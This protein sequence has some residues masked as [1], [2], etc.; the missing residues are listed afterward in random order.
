MYLFASRWHVTLRQSRNAQG[1]NLFGY[2]YVSLTPREDSSAIFFK[3][4][5]ERYGPYISELRPTALDGNW[6]G[7]VLYVK[8][9][10][11]HRGIS[12]LNVALML[13]QVEKSV[14]TVFFAEFLQLIP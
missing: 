6:T 11:S 7:N 10:Q 13:E 2:F 8:N 3:I 14:K 5:N 9:H 12:K 1:D 4:E